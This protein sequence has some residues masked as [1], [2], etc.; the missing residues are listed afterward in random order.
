[1]IVKSKR[2]LWLSRN[3][4]R[5]NHWGAQ[6][7]NVETVLGTG[8]PKHAPLLRILGWRTV[9]APKARIMKG[10]K[11][12]ERVPQTRKLWSAAALGCGK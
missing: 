11:V 7:L 5:K 9:S 6:N 4:R 10:T 1:M 12:K 2:F 3:R 8:V